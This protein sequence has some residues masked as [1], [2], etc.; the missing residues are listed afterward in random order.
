[1]ARAVLVI[2]T[3]PGSEA[4]DVLPAKPP[5]QPTSLPAG[6]VEGGGASG[7]DTLCERDAACWRDGYTF[8]RCCK[9][10][11]ILA[12]VAGCWDAEYT[13]QRCCHCG[14]TGK[15]VDDAGAAPPPSAHGLPS[16]EA[17]TVPAVEELLPAPATA[18]V[19][20]GLV[21]EELTEV[22]RRD[23]EADA[24]Q[25]L[26][27]RREG[28]RRW[29]AYF[30]KAQRLLDAAVQRSPGGEE[31][32]SEPRGVDAVRMYHLL[33]ETVNQVVGGVQLASEASRT[34][35]P[36]APLELRRAGAAEGTGGT[37]GLL[38][39][40][41]TVVA[42]GAAVKPPPIGSGG[43]GDTALRAA[44]LS[45]AVALARLAQ[46]SRGTPLE[47]E[48][49][50][51]QAGAAVALSCRQQDKQVFERDM[52]LR[53]EWLR[54]GEEEG[55]EQSWRAG[56][57][58]ALQEGLRPGAA[59]E[60]LRP[61]F[62]RSWRMYAEDLPEAVWRPAL[63]RL[64]EGEGRMTGSALNPLDDRITRVSSNM[65][66]MWQIFP[67]YVLA[68][69]FRA[70]LS[71]GGSEGERHTSGAGKAEGTE[72]STASSS[73]PA[74]AELSRIVLAK[75]QDF[76]RTIQNGTEGQLGTS[77]AEADRP[78]VNNAFFAWQLTHESEQEDQRGQ[79]HWPELYRDSEDFKRLRRVAKLACLEYL[80]QVYDAQ[81]SIVDLA[82]LEL[83]I[84]ASVTTT[85]DDA[86]DGDS[87][88]TMGLA[89]HDHPLALLSGVF[90][91]Q[92][93]GSSV[94]ERTPTVFAD[95]RGLPAFRYTR[96]PAWRGREGSDPMDAGDDF[97]DDEGSLEPTAPFH[98]M[99]YAHAAEG[100][101]LVFP[102]WLV[103]GVPPHGG[104]ST[105]VTFA[106]N[107]HTLH[108]TTFSAWAKTTL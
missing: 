53:L 47:H 38:A 33:Y 68:K 99:A 80:Q 70:A 50:G 23:T 51:A 78:K 85:S 41:G 11:A 84:W 61:A 64:E 58:D 52:A 1:M 37:G 4:V 107:L 79:R 105:R 66:N 19:V 48:D 26:F 94:A 81:L 45:A 59:E 102:A 86:K 46:A 57:L 76:E 88:N 17:A 5:P 87:V 32:G 21:A 35:A 73:C 83:S 91:A 54:H 49:F 25:D 24:S 65:G 43:Q 62:E 100:H 10:P 55:K 27:F 20:A 103:H 72:T 60:A 2:V 77:A 93:G 9:V 89:L 98:R 13:E 71:R 7:R 90:Y 42:G 92:A 108:G 8:A 36:A 29:A 74:C 14:G 101:A 82:Q 30:R 63:G 15:G 6:L 28:S 12:A 75:Y 69:P 97:V 44:F 40:A 39:E 95:P 56:L 67:T 22:Q 34:S 16:E 104:S 18:G 106:F 3:R 31:E 96:Q